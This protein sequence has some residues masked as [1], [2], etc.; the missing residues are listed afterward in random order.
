MESD[1]GAGNFVGIKMTDDTVEHSGSFIK[2]TQSL[3]EPEVQKKMIE[4]IFSEDL[5]N[6]GVYYL[7]NAKWW[8]MWVHYV[9]FQNRPPGSIEPPPI[10]NEPLFE[11]IR[12][13]ILVRHLQEGR[14][15]EFL[16]ADVW[17]MLT[18]W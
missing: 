17:N 4:D 3:P 16:A 9:G 13:G 1:H 8:E 10:N 18:S 7:I 11:D 15:F 6:G 2:A 12:T 5:V 14:H